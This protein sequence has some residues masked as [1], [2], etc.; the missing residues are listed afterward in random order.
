MN[1]ETPERAGART[2]SPIGALYRKMSGWY[3]AFSLAL[4]LIILFVGYRL[5]RPLL[6]LFFGG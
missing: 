4:L 5:T 6:P 1:A 3:I 2:G